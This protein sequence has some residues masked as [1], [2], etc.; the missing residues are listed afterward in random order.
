MATHFSA[1]QYEN[2]F[3]AKR[4]QNWETPASF[5][6]RPSQLDGFTRPIANNRGHLLQGISRSQK[7]PWGGFAGTWD[8]NQ[9][10]KSIPGGPFKNL[11]CDGAAEILTV[12]S[13]SPQSQLQSSKENAEKP[14]P[15]PI[16]EP[17]NERS[18]GISKHIKEVQAMERKEPEKTLSPV[19]SP[20]PKTAERDLTPADKC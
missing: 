9:N 18:I 19:A 8:S 17:V 12:H 11:Q 1:N 2:A 14:P 5:K 15:S 3:A 20:V 7:C 10:K 4:L 6:E 16:P 13:P